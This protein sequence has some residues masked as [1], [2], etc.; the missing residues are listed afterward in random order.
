MNHT[1]MLSTNH[2]VSQKPGNIV[3]DMDGEKVMLSV[4]NG[5]YYNMGDIGGVIWERMKEPIVIDKLITELTNIYDV[6][7]SV[8][9][10][11]VLSFLDHLAKEQL[12]RVTTH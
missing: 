5:K 2:I 8:C 12:I 11:H 3:S 7:V 4:K 6:A 10:E 9:E 1:Q